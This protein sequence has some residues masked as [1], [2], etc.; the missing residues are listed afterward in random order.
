[1]ERLKLLSD[2]S[3][4]L[5][6]SKS[7]EGQINSVLECI[8]NHTG[9]SRVYIFEDSSDRTTTTNTFEWCNDNIEPQIANLVSI[10]YSM[11]PSWKLKLDLKNHFN[12]SDTSQAPEDVRAVLEPQG[13][14]SILVDSLINQDKIWGFIGYDECQYKREWSLEEKE[15][16]K[17]R[18]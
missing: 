4:V 17:I 9:V 7:L 10:P 6:S 12:Y 15:L 14:S 1:M 8:G 11:L 5:S 18:D 2:V 13:I 16:L 3:L